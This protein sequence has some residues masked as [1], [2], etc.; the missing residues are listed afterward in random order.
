MYKLVLCAVLVSVVINLV[1]P[2]SVKP[3]ATPEQIKPPNG[4]ENLPFFD[5]L[6]HMFVHHAQVPLTSSLIVAVIVALSVVCGYYLEFYGVHYMFN[7]N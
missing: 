5:Q 3:F 4:A 2:F 1:L 6:M 7:I